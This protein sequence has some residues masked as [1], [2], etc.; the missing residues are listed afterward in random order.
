MILFPLLSVNIKK[1]ILE[2]AALMKYFSS[3]CSAN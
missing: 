1:K 3:R 2:A